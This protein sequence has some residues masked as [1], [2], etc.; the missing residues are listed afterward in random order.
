MPPTKGDHVRLDFTGT[1]DKMLQWE[2]CDMSCFISGNQC[3]L[4]WA[5]ENM[6][7]HKMYIM[8]CMTLFVA[9]Y[10]GVEMS[11][12]MMSQ[13]FVS[14]IVQYFTHKVLRCH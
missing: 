6:T 9:H 14:R 4:K 1:D 5:T 12:W 2:I 11:R 10:K 3:D 13:I 7:R 8:R